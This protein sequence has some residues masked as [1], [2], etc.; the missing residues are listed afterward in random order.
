MLNESW[1]QICTAPSIMNIVVALPVSQPVILCFPAV[2][3]H[4]RWKY[5]RHTKASSIDE[6]ST[7][8]KT[9]RSLFSVLPSCWAVKCAIFILY[10]TRA[11][12]NN[13]G[14]SEAIKWR[15]QV[16]PNALRPRKDIFIWSWNSAV[17]K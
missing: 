8:L 16:A 11:T 3:G 2:L 1:Q 5:F 13:G 12:N 17:P 4:K 14:K 10:K 6:K 9:S 15:A 7:S